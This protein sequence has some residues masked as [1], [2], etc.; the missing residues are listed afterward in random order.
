MKFRLGDIRARVNHAKILEFF[1]VKGII[2]LQ[3]I[4]I[5]NYCAYKQEGPMSH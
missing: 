2:L 3:T 1:S 4:Y 5:T